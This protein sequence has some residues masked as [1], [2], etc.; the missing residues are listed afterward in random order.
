MPTR[1]PRKLVLRSPTSKTSEILDVHMTAELLTVSPDTIYDLFKTG[2][3]PGRKVGR[4]W[5]TT[6]TAVLRWIENSAEEDTLARAIEQGDAKAL[7]A[8]L[9]S[10]Q[11]QVKK[12]A[13]PLPVPCSGFAIW[14]YRMWWTSS[15]TAPAYPWTPIRSRGWL[16]SRASIVRN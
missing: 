6:R 4:K 7:A 9:K 1:K 12:R 13:C 5:L 16:T 11:V 3:L 14:R 2:E 15:L 8:A 10:G